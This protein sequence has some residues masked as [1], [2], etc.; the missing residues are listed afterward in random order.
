MN[1]NLFGALSGAL[2]SK[3]RKET[4]TAPDGSTRAVEERD[5]RGE[6]LSFF[7][8]CLLLTLSVAVAQGAARGQGS[9]YAAAEAEEGAK[10]GRERAAGQVQEAGQGRVEK[11]V[12]H[13]G[14]EG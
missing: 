4:H 5:T 7:L 13:L 1:L 8:T 11:K 12:D 2:S 6:F 9:A 3:S 10:K 14:I